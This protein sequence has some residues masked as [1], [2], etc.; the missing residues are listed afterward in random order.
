MNCPH[1]KIPLL[2]TDR[3]GI[4]IDYCSACRGV[5]L[6]RGELDKIIELSTNNNANTQNHS[7]HNQHANQNQANQRPQ[8]QSDYQS[9][10]HYSKHKKPK[11]MLGEIFDIF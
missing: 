9:Q 11:S 1:C 7:S 4:E 2:M 6:D 3:Q 8:Y 5:W 10:K